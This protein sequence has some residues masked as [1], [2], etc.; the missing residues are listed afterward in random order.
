MQTYKLGLF[1]FKFYSIVTSQTFVLWDL[2]RTGRLLAFRS[3]KRS[4]TTRSF[5]SKLLKRNRSYH[6]IQIHSGQS[7]VCISDVCAYV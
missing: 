7:F 2:H 1:F 5:K 4:K 6:R 3:E